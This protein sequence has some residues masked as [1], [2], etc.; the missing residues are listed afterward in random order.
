MSV[1]Q[2]FLSARWMEKSRSS[3]AGGKSHGQIQAEKRLRSGAYQRDGAVLSIRQIKR[4]NEKKAENK[5]EKRQQEGASAGRKN[6]ENG[7]FRRSN[8][9]PKILNQRVKAMARH[10][11]KN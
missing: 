5:N 11:R 3:Q 9:T 8:R 7:I 10:Q 2:S 6:S 1:A 4:L